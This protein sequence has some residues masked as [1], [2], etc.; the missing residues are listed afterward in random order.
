M[1]SKTRNVFFSHKPDKSVS[2]EWPVP[3]YHHRAFGHIVSPFLWQKRVFKWHSTRQLLTQA[4]VTLINYKVANLLYCPQNHWCF[5]CIKQW[6]FYSVCCINFQTSRKT[7]W[8]LYLYYYYLNLKQFVCLKKREK[9]P[10][11][12]KQLSHAH[13]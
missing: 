11:V 4:L 6:V 2:V 12:E 10:G 7:D 5:G 3:H 1:E 8:P 13:T 9:S